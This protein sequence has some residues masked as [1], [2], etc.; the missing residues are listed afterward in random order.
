MWQYVQWMSGVPLTVKLPLA[1]TAS[2]I[3]GNGVLERNLRL[4]LHTGVSKLNRRLSIWPQYKN[5]LHLSEL[6]HAFSPYGGNGFLDLV[7]EWF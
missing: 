1:L 3:N 5:S 4:G 6:P 2:G 7:I